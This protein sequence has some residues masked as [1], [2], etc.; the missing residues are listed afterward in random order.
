MVIQRHTEEFQ[1]K[2]P[3]LCLIE[4]SNNG[5]RLKLQDIEGGLSHLAGLRSYSVNT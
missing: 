5:D 4:N 2:R 3:R 1:V